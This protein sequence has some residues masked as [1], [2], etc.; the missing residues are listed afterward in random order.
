MTS[1]FT[2]NLKKFALGWILLVTFTLSFTSASDITSFAPNSVSTFSGL[3]TDG[4]GKSV[5]IAG[6]IDG[7][8]INDLIIGDNKQGS[9]AGAVYVIYGTK[10]LG[11][12]NFDFSSSL[13]PSI[14]FMI[15]GVDAYG[16]L[17][18][19]VSSGDVDSDGVD[20]IIIGASYADSL[21][22]KVYVIYGCSRVARTSID[23][24]N[25][26]PSSD[27]FSL[28][29]VASGGQL[30]YS[31]SSGDINSDGY[32]D[33]IVG[34]FGENNQRGA[35]YIVYGGLRA[36]FTSMLT[37]SLNS[38]STGF[39]ITG[40]MAGTL[41]GFAVSTGDLDGDGYA[42][43]VVGARGSSSRK[44]VVYVIY[45]GVKSS[46]PDLD[47][48]TTPDLSYSSSPPGFTIT[49]EIAN[50]YFGNALSVGDVD[51]DELEDILIG[52][53]QASSNTGSVYVI[54]GSQPRPSSIDI[55][56]GLA[57]SR[58]FKITGAAAGD[59]FGWSVSNV[60]HVNNDGYVDIVI[61]AKAA[62]SNLGGVYVIYGG[63]RA[64]LPTVS[65]VSATL[66]PQTQGFSLSG[67]YAGSFFGVSVNNAGDVNDDGYDD[68]LIGAYG[69]SK[70][71]LL[72]YSKRNY[73]E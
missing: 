60:G 35:A 13:D 21:V 69:E 28:S 62:N 27:G 63:D 70:A 49:G 55:S 32:D 44:G 61:G 42:D 7:D 10:D 24:N 66:D 37:T 2:K 30:G 67:T 23:L 59:Y 33:I 52:A 14:G 65:S 15:S 46:L 58:G 22:G 12:S 71:Y 5:S 3:P 47:L 53:A 48:S 16:Q 54:Y 29:G 40:A 18:W 20:D 34:A 57:S 50:D 51:N 17:G 73:N 11:T 41:C 8:G 64:A 31:V 26:T 43:I 38:A 36:S 45:G 68:I 4:L 25:L 1:R 6:D 9:G 39:K 19:A 72:I 56:T